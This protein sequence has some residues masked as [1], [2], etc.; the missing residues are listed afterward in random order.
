MVDCE[1]G[2]L[3]KFP[4]VFASDFLARL[5]LKAGST[6]QLFMASGLEKWRLGPLTTASK[7]LGLIRPAGNG[8]LCFRLT[9]LTGRGPYVRMGKWYITCCDSYVCSPLVVMHTPDYGTLAG[10]NCLNVMSCT[11]YL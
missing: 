7:G 11:R 9:W 3:L 8:F 10:D 6:A 4:R 1:L 2:K 5:G